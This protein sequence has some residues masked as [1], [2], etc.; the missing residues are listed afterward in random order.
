MIDRDIKL[1]PQIG[2]HVDKVILKVKDFGNNVQRNE[3]RTN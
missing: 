3:I 2:L 1:D